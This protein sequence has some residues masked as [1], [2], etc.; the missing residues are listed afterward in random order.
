MTY[1]W[2]TKFLK[3]SKDYKEEIKK[4]IKKN[5]QLT[6]ISNHVI[7]NCTGRYLKLLK[8]DK[9]KTK[10]DILIKSGLNKEFVIDT[11]TNGK[12]ILIFK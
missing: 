7:H 1:S 3:L 12:R 5:K 11:I 8:E 10:S 2:Y 6:K 9:L 4:L